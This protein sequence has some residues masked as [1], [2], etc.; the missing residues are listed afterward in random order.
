M[1]SRLSQALDDTTS[2]YRDATPA[3][4][5]RYEQ[6]CRT[7]PGGNTRS[8]LHYDPYPVTITR[9]LGATVWDVDDNRYT[10]FLGEYSAGL[11]GHSNPRI[12]AAVKSVL[13]KG[14]VLCAPNQYESELADIIRE[15]SR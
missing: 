9:G 6:S 4:Q 8:I 1:K 2:R 12:S 10:D 5:A 11:Y 13:D 15:R 3:S 14:I 7:M